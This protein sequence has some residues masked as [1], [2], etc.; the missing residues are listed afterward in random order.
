MKRFIT[1]SAK[2]R[3]EV[4][5]IIRT[6]LVREATTDAYH[7]LKKHLLDGGVSH[8][9]QQAHHHQ[10]LPHQG[11]YVSFYQDNNG[12]WMHVAH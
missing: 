5:R 7:W 8:N 4:L 9:D 3:E 1:V 12:Q 11:G 2:H 6:V 10:D